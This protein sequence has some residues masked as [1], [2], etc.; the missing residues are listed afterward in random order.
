MTTWGELLRKNRLQASVLVALALLFLLA[1]QGMSTQDGVITTLRGLSVGAVTFLTA[2]GLS[3]IFGL[4][5][6]LNLAHGAFF[7]F[8]AYIGWTVFVRPDTVIDLAT[9]LALI[10]GGVL[11]KPVWE[12]LL[13]RRSLGGAIGRIWPWAA[14][15]AGAG[16]TFFGL[17]NAPVAIWNAADYQQSPIA[18]TILLQQGQRP[19]VAAAAYAIS[20][21]I[22]LAS[23]I[24]GGAL[25]A[26]GGAGFAQGRSSG[27]KIDRGLVKPLIL[28]VGL[29]VTGLIVFLINQPLTEWLFALDT[30][31]LFII[32]LTTAFLVGLG[33]GSAMEATLIRPLYT[34]PMY[35]LMLT[36]GI[37]VIGI[38]VVRAWWGRSQIDMPRPALFSVSGGA[39][40]A[41]TVG[42]WLANGCSTIRFMDGRIRTYNEIF[43][44]VVGL[45]VLIGVWLLLQRSRLGMIIRAGVQDREMVEALGINVRRVFT[46]VFGLGVGLAAFG[47]AV[48][49]PSLGLTAEMGEVVLLGALIALV[50]GG[51]TSFP[52]AA[53]GAIIVGLVQQFIIKY[54][55]IG[56][57]LPFLAEPFK[58]SP[59]LV[60]ASTV[61][62]MVVILLIL[63][64]GLLGRKE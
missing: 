8:G 28:S 64:Q 22:G 57:Q 46:L 49:G 44:I 11:L 47:G 18:L 12:A 63:P 33:L 25:L 45:V 52:G 19:S 15:I 14:L 17:S 35:Q 48:A 38:E 24:T 9:P 1:T 3:L 30:N 50:I 43:V 39:C 61:L 10:A 16:V 58:P 53:V 59:P 23:L 5:D 40:P 36:L 55:Q 26:L 2:A 42:D 51:L 4:M 27:A 6:V 21:L 20:P 54:G 37:G 60:P 32:G 29:I 31:W 13:A 56:I 34:R 41:S 62:L 7:M